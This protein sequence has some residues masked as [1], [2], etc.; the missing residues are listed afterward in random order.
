MPRFLER[1][2]AER[3]PPCAKYPWDGVRNVRP[4]AKLRDGRRRR[5]VLMPV[6]N[7]PVPHL[8][9]LRWGQPYRS[10]DVATAVHFRTREPFVEVSQ[11][12]LGLIRRDLL[13][14]AE[15]A[16]GAGRRFR[17][18]ELVAMVEARRRAVPERRRCR[19][20]RRAASTQT[21]QRLRRAGLGDDRHAA[22]P[23]CAA[24]CSRCT[25]C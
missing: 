3:E 24:T 25:A 23:S 21:P 13:E 19:S 4:F 5:G 16:R 11:A 9:I 1:D 7:A 18:R 6:P 15:R 20:I 12:N 2:E 17:T 22:R 10:V 8:P 14:Q